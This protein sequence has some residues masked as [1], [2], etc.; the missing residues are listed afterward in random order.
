[1]FYTQVHRMRVGIDAKVRQTDLDLQARHLL[2]I[3]E[4]LEATLRI[5]LGE[6][7]IALSKTEPSLISKSEHLEELLLM[8]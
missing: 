2:V 3:F 8:S 6:T 4:N 1:M 7:E 5:I